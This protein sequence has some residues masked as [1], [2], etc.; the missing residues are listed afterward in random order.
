MVAFLIVKVSWGNNV[1][2]LLGWYFFVLFYRSDYIRSE[3][4]QAFKMCFLK[5][6][7]CLFEL[8]D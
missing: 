5:G 3:I 6:E 1:F 4:L 8:Q 7:M 2:I